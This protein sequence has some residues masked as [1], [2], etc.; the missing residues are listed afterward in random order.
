MGS[1][2][3]LYQ[4][5]YSFGAWKRQSSPGKLQLSGRLRL[6]AGH[7]SGKGKKAEIMSSGDF[8]V[9]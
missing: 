9:V 2:D 4:A 3:L 7:N 5:D 1:P 8:G 6:S